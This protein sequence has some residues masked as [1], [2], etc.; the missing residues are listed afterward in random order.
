MP[1]GYL[2]IGR[3]EK[4]ESLFVFATCFCGRR[5]YLVILAWYKFNS[6]K[7]MPPNAYLERGV[8]VMASGMSSKSICVV[9][10]CAAISV[11]ICRPA[12]CP[13]RGKDTLSCLT[14]S[15]LHVKNA[16]QKG[17]HT[18]RFWW[19]QFLSHMTL[20]LLPFL[21]ALPS[22]TCISI[23]FQGCRRT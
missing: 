18:Y 6:N 21:V 10:C 11:Q 19:I 15:L 16:N 1:R 12:I 23:I 8:W 20:I 7:H 5:I 14:V 4:T 2:L 3:R 22:Q 13:S 9:L 17:V